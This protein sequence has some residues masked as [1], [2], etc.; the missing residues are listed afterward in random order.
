M[1]LTLIL[2][3]HAKSDWKAGLSDHERPLNARGRR[4]ATNLGKWLKENGFA[5]DEALVS[6]A[7]RTVETYDRLRCD[8]PMRAV[9]ALYLAEAHEMRDVLMQASGRVVLMVGHNPGIAELAEALVETPPDDGN[10]LRYPTGATSVIRF[11]AD[12]W[13]Q[14]APGEGKVVDFVVPRALDEG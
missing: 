12:G 10:F 5:P 11:D 6:D 13:T 3:R 9:P 14:V 8:A 7:A 4:S 2:M 1:P